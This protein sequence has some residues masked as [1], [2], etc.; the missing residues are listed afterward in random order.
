MAKTGLHQDRFASYRMTGD[1]ITQSIAHDERMVQID[2]QF[3]GC[4]L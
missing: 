4:P 1:E 2:L 3:P